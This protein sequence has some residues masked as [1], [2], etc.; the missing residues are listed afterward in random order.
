MTENKE[1]HNANVVN[2]RDH[3]FIGLRNDSDIMGRRHSSRFPFL[4]IATALAENSR[5]ICCELNAQAN[6]ITIYVNE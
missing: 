5:I 2:W 6:K 3:S 4:F 1:Y